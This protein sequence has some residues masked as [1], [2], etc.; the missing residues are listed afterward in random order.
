MAGASRILTNKIFMTTY[1]DFVRTRPADDVHR[2][3]HDH[4]YG[5]PLHTDNALFERLVLEINQAGLSWETILKKKENF[6]RAYEGFDVDRVA[7][8]TEADRERLLSDAGIIRNKLKVN[9]AIVNA[10]RIVALRPEYG[11]FK[12][13]LDAHLLDATHHPLIKDEWVKTFKK[14]F[15][16]VGGEIAAPARTLR[17]TRTSRRRGIDRR[18]RAPAP[19]QR[20]PRLRG[21]PVR[22]RCV[23]RRPGTYLAARCVSPAA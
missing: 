1:C 14:I 8:Y 13:W 16:F 22:L 5:F 7:N 2:H 19:R 12:G 15:V 3:Y 9:A 20:I 17:R 11:S 6:Q 10:Q 23:R 4:D 18:V 21:R